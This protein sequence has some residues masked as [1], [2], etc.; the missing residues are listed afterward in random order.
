MLDLI[1][2]TGPYLGSVHVYRPG[3]YSPVEVGGVW[4]EDDLWDGDD[5]PEA[6]KPF[7]PHMEEF[8]TKLLDAFDATEEQKDMVFD[9]G[10]SQRGVPPNENCNLCMVSHLYL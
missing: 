8:V 4:S 9:A 7:Y 1:P 3:I 5:G 6:F 10:L 2:L